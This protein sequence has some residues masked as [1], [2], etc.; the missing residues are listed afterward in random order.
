MSENLIIQLGSSKNKTAVTTDQFISVELK[1]SSKEIL[2]Y[3]ES[4]VI[5]VADLF[6]TERQESEL[7]RIYGRIDFISIMNG[8]KKNYTTLTDF[9]TPARLGD[10]LS[11]V[12]KN[13]PYSFD[14]YLCY[15]AS[16]N[17]YISGNTYIRNY[18]VA[19][20]LINGEIYK[21]G[22]GRNI[23]F[24]YTYSFDFNID[25]NLE[26]YLDSFNKPITELYLYFV[27]KK[28]NN[29]NGQPED[30][31]RNNWTGGTVPI[32]YNSSTGYS[33]GE[34][35]VGDKVTYELENFVE[36][37]N[38]RL[39]HYINLP[40]DGSEILQFKYNPFIPIKIRDFGDELITANIS[41]GTENDLNI[42]W[43]AVPLDN[44]GNYIWKDILP[45][46]YI[47]PI[48][49]DGVDYP[50]INKRHY[51]FNA[52]ALPVIPNLDDLNT[53]NIFGKIKF[54]PN[55]QINKKPNSPLN[56]LGNRCA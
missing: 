27:Y 52:L 3:N 19:S 26:G 42:P 11:G 29:G 2:S 36:V 14:M 9:F 54:G 56:N 12:T 51:I 22:F 10:E 35:L 23:Y 16:A 55:S 48:T 15:P 31:F 5:D 1:N 24:N 30:Y 43:Y 49:G 13:L 32:T 20:K 21:S 34:L 4:S 40:Y 7:Y 50:F 45:N 8:L 18:V 53:S 38:E 44:R 33:V 25:F 46:G 41:G 6:D 28:T 17:T 37:L 47:D 39:V